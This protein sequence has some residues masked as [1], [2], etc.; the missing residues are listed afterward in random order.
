MRLVKL[1]LVVAS[2]VSTVGCSHM[3]NRGSVVLKH[4]NSE[5][6]ICIGNKEIKIGDKLNFYQTDCVMTG[7]GR[8]SKR[9]CSKT[10]I[11][12]GEVISTQDEHFSTVKLGSEF[13]VTAGTVVE[14]QK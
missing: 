10:K 5:V 6:D 8:S 12:E 3:H 9:S 14:K 11:G 13:N 7:T 1:S 2:I 4:S